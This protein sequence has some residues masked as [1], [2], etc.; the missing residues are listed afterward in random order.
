MIDNGKICTHLDPPPPA[1]WK[2]I[3]PRIRIK[4]EGPV[5]CKPEFKYNSAAFSSKKGKYLALFL[6]ETR[7]QHFFYKNISA[8]FFSKSGNI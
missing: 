1:Q 6:N 4:V 3:Y 7:C 8:I 5:I 2:N